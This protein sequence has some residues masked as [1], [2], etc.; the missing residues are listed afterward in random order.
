M[1][2]AKLDGID[3]YA[4]FFGGNAPLITVRTGNEGP[5]LLILRDSFMDSMS[6]FLLPH[7]S[8]IHI[9]DLRYYKYSVQDYIREHGIDQVLVCYSVTNFVQDSSLFVMGQ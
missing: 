3:K 8:E 4:Y 9:M 1:Q 2:D 5:K 7:F 6:P